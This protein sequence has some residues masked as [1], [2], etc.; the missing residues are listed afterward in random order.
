[1][2]N[3]VMKPGP[4]L[5]DIERDCH[6]LP[7]PQDGTF[8]A[9]RGTTVILRDFLRKRVGSGPEL[10]RQLPAR[11]GLERSDWHVEVHHS[12][13][14]RG[15]PQQFVLRDLPVDVMEETRIDVSKR[16]GSLPPGD[17]MGGLFRTAPIGT[18]RW[19]VSDLR[20]A[21]WSHRPGISVSRRVTGEF[22][23]RSRLVG[24][25]HADWLDD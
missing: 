9:E 25:V 19:L 14:D 1:M 13:A 4:D 21:S 12:I 3:I 24:A 22:E 15:A 23:L 10:S 2:A 17:R 11:F 5:S 7:G 20:A 8:S 16:P 18:R 6:P